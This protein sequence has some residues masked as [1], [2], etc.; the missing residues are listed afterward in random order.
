ML[1][2]NTWKDT[3]HILFK[4]LNRWVSVFHVFKNEY[5]SVISAMWF[6][7]SKCNLVC[8]YISSW[9]YPR[10]SSKTLALRWEGGNWWFIH[11]NIYF[12]GSWGKC[13]PL[14]VHLSGL[15]GMG[16]I[17]VVSTLFSVKGLC[18]VL[19]LL[20]VS[21]MYGDNVTSQQNLKAKESVSVSCA[22]K[23]SLN[24]ILVCLGLLLL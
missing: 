24:Q 15:P 11:L 6:R 13:C 7:V 1:C 21:I 22:L 8:F 9:V 2:C 20:P 19:L 23:I 5:H 10:E 16:T 18:Y 17:W 4:S 14:A 12:F 3:K